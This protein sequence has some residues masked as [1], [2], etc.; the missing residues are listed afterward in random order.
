MVKGLGHVLIGGGTGFIGKA[1]SRILRN[2]GYNVTV[3]SRMPGPKR[4]TWH[5]VQRVGLPQDV[6]AVVNLAGQ[7]VLDVTRRW[8][9]GFKQN[10][11]N[12]RIQTTCALAKAI[13]DAKDKPAVFITISGVGIYKPDNHIVYSENVAVSQ[14]DFFSK[15][16]FEWENAAKLPS[17][18]STRHGSLGGPIA[19]GDQFL[20]WIHIDD[21]SRLFVFAIESTNIS[22]VLNGV[23]PEE[24]SN[25]E[26]SACFAK[27]LFRP[28]LIPV[29]QAALNMILGE[30]RA[31]MLTTGP[32]V[33]PKRTLSLG[34]KFLYPDI[35]SACDEI[36]HTPKVKEL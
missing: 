12:S 28:A 4:I 1:L 16:C 29:P 8:T 9:E 22:G 27:T 34:F 5:D 24:I 20:P 25:K 21:I 14:F 32:R 7:N 13:T 17:H 33:Q 2:R 11:W 30:E 19:P 36:V 18:V 3:V 15:L 35:K 26:F 10:V 31:S 23:A 6:T